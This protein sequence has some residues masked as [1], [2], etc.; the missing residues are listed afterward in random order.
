MHNTAKVALLYPQIC[1]E[2]NHAIY[3]NGGELKARA[4]CCTSLREI[5]VIKWED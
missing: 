5:Q 2:I 3:P 4:R 1:Y